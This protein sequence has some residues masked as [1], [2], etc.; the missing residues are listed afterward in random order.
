MRRSA[1]VCA[2]AFIVVLAV[3]ACWD[4]SIRVL[5]VAEALPYLL[6]A[7]LVLRGHKLGYALGSAAGAFWLFTATCR[8]SFVRNGFARLAHGDW[9]RPDLLIAVPAA[10]AT[11]GLALFC[12]I[13]YARLPRKAWSDVLLFA[14]AFVLVAAFFLTIFAAFAPRYLELF[15]GLLPL[16]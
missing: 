8:T 11:G 2:A 14:G 13:G 4:R 1:A 9:S 16:P 12:A 3:S 7:I 6:A 15:R 5:H 10:L